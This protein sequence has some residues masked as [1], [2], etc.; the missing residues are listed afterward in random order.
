MAKLRIVITAEHVEDDRRFLDSETAKYCAVLRTAGFDLEC[1]VTFEAHE[2]AEKERRSIQQERIRRHN[3][4]AASSV[5]PPDAKAPAKPKA[6]A[7]PR[8]RAKPKA[9]K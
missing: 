3:R 1:K 8:A 7:K 6:K 4:P 5:E 9:K 2:D